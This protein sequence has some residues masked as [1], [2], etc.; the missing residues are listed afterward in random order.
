MNDVFDFRTQ[1]T[2][3]YASFSRGVS[4]VLADDLRRVME[5]IDKN[6]Q[7][8]WPAPLIQLNLSY[9]PG[10]SVSA[11]VAEGKL[12][13]DCPKI[14]RF[15]QDEMSLYAHQKQAIELYRS[16]RNYVVTTGTGSGK[17][18]TF[19]IPIVDA[20]LRG[21]EREPR[22]RTRALIVYPMNALANSQ[23]EEIRKYLRQYPQADIS[24]ERYTGIENEEK[25]RRIAAAPPD[26]LLTNYEM[27][28]LLL[29]RSRRETD[30]LV[31]Q[32]CEGLDFLVLDELHTYR[33]R[34]GADIAMLVRRLR[35]ATAAHH[36]L[37]IG[38]SATMSSSPNADVRRKEVATVATKLFGTPVE[39]ENVIEESLRRITD[40]SIR[41]D[42]VLAAL[43]SYLK[44]NPSFLWDTAPI[45]TDPL[46]IWVEL[47]LGINIT[48]D[49]Y[50]RARPMNLDEL[51]NRLA[52]ESGVEKER[53]KETLRRFLLAASKVEIEHRHPF[54]FKLH[55]FIS[56]PGNIQVT[57]EPV[58]KRYIT[59]EGQVESPKNKRLYSAWFCR[60]C[61][62]EYLPVWYNPTEKT[63]L[64]RD[65]RE[66]RTDTHYDEEGNSTEL[67]AGFL[68]LLLSR[69]T[70][71]ETGEQRPV[72][73]G[74]EDLDA[75]PDEWF[76]LTARGARRLR[77]EKSKF[78]PRTVRLNAD[79]QLDAAGDDFQYFAAG[80][81]FCPHCGAVSETARSSDANR[82][83][84]IS[85]EGRSSASSVLTLESL[86]ILNQEILSCANPDEKEHL[87]DL[88]KVLGFSDNRQDTALQAG[89]FNDLLSKLM[90][91]AAQLHA[92]QHATAPLSESALVAAVMHALHLD[93]DDDELLRRV[94]P[95]TLT[96]RALDRPRDLLRF[97]L[98]YRMLTALRS[99]W[100]YMHPS[101]EQVNLLR[102]EYD[103]MEALV[104]DTGLCTEDAYRSL[105]TAGKRTIIRLVLEELRA[106]LFIVSSYLDTAQ[107]DAFRREA[108]NT[109]KAPWN[110]I[111][112]KDAKKTRFYYLRAE[113]K[114]RHSGDAHAVL[115]HHSSVFRALK[116]KAHRMLEG[117]D[118]ETWASYVQQSNISES[119][120]SFIGKVLRAGVRHGITTTNRSRGYA[121]SSACLRW[122]LPSGETPSSARG[123][124]YFAE[125]YLRMAAMLE[126]DYLFLFKLAASEHTAQ[127]DNDERKELEMRFRNDRSAHREWEQSHEPEDSLIP[128]PVLYCSPTMELGVDIS[129]LNVV[130]MRNVPP[131]PANYAQ[132]AGRAGRSGE[133]AISV[134]YCHT[135]SPHDQW[136]FHDP[137]A[138]VCGAVKAPAIDLQNRDLVE[139]HLRSILLGASGITLD[140]SIYEC[141]DVTQE[142]LPLRADIREA[143]QSP[144]TKDKAE[145]MAREAFAGLSTEIRDTEENAWFHDPDFIRRTLDNA[146]ADM[147]KALES[148]RS[149]Y[150]GTRHLLNEA[151][152]RIQSR[153][154]T[155]TEK[156]T[157]GRRYNEARAQLAILETASGK[158]N[159]YEPYRYLASQGYIPGYNFPRLPILAWIPGSEADSGMRVLSR[160]R[161]LGLSEFG[162]FS[163]IYHRGAIYRANRIKLRAKEAGTQL[164]TQQIQI[165]ERCGHA[166]FVPQNSAR[167]NCCEHCNHAGLTAIPSLYH[168][169]A[170]ETELVNHITSAE[171]ERQRQGFEMQ[172]CYT[173]AAKNGILSMK[174]TDVLDAH[175]KLLGTFTYGPAATLYK[176][177]KGWN[178]RVNKNSLGFHVN[179]LSG[180]WMGEQAAPQENNAPAQPRQII[181]P[182]VKDTRNI[183]LF[184]PAELPSGADSYMPTLQAALHVGIT[185]AFQVEASEIGIEP[186][187]DRNERRSLLIYEAS[188]G[189]SGVLHGLSENPQRL[190][191]VAYEALCAMHYAPSA[192]PQALTDTEANKNEEQRCNKACYRCLLSYT[193]QPDHSNIDRHQQEVCALLQSFFSVTFRDQALPPRRSAEEE[194]TPSA[195]W[196]AELIARE[197]PEPEYEVSKLGFTFFALFKR[198]RVAVF[199]GAEP[200]NAHELDDF[201]IAHLTFPAD[202]G[203]WPPLFDELST[204]L[205]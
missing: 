186:L 192:L 198:R 63:Y 169:D 160:P 106:K 86:D 137:A 15:G 75:L 120:L 21:K 131:S 108:A 2:E 61:G 38:T 162:P 77:K 178:R 179:P 140:S 163:L 54:A 121:L 199:M 138:M 29:T 109:L 20:V 56:A 150:F 154:S 175:G 125:L 12:H 165:C 142:N 57:L 188:E 59:V 66:K 173:F 41:R 196:K 23:L 32:H 6:R 103:N 80:F 146:S 130:Y 170:I 101:P 83:V 197:L 118:K 44:G 139:S 158:N 200:P 18:L 53:C 64:P 141:L 152:A 16:H 65:I 167:L 190:Q 69:N 110:G 24:V 3:R 37:C 145:R 14:F 157:A 90:M 26:I 159:E 60:D 33:G 111:P 58:G 193:N 67:Q 112:N 149:L 99:E 177:N 91:S 174:R 168:I 48:A 95:H 47:T 205:S 8:Y 134:T 70:D 71:P 100:R 113:D 49:D 136:F 4:R 25:R 52:T 43:P 184:E 96:G 17:S 84:S 204:L 126:T 36:L 78:R 46:A 155:L 42:E 189:G 195:R 127:V 98:G 153:T 176:I 203:A 148:W 9:Q 143:L 129:S 180:G 166:H 105:S 11:L 82:L 194:S 5:D 135:M 119:L 45:A 183:L 181:V 122:L 51:A 151:N 114:P 85:G 89:H 117:A 22:P 115:S 40:T 27:L 7:I 187:P 35:Q 97:Y 72:Y 133:T 39:P 92:L 147:E 50:R 19:F 93:E 30:R 172:T 144:A 94:I 201:G 68:T 107:Q 76:E 185:R 128:L 104:Q 79:G 1:L 10:G 87:R 164:P 124:R 34:Q 73:A 123:N 81:S 191:Q 182:Y 28:E 102:I 62:K 88:W 116:T 55:Q 156:N 13:P 31:M 132:R 202:E 161:F 74:E 171:E